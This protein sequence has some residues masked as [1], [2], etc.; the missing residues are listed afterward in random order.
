MLAVLNSL[1]SQLDEEIRDTRALIKDLMGVN[2]Q[3]VDR[4]RIMERNVYRFQDS[5]RTK[6][7][8]PSTNYELTRKERYDE[9]QQVIRDV[10]K[11]NGE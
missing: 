3:V 10:G 5:V 9:A 11:I 8:I 2:I 7:D 4:V 1:T 6:F